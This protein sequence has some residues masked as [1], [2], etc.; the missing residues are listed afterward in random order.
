MQ[1]LETFHGLARKEKKKK[2]KQRSER[3]SDHS[4]EL[5]NILTVSEYPLSGWKS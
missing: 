1:Q 3:Q 5:V 4:V 2:E